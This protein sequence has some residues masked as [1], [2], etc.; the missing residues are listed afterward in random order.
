MAELE[1]GRA[2]PGDYEVFGSE[3]KTTANPNKALLQSRK[4]RLL[5]LDTVISCVLFWVG[6]YATGSVDDATI[7]IG[8]LQ[9]VFVAIIIAISIEDA[10]EK[11]SGNI[12]PR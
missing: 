4:F 3:E 9:P 8:L 2:Q 11:A 5:V 7:L 10:A 12:T 6:K 1:V